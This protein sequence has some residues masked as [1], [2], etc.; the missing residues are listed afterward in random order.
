MNPTSILIGILALAAVVAAHAGLVLAGRR[1]HPLFILGGA[2]LL[3]APLSMADDFQ[4]VG[5]IKFARLY[6]TLLM[7]ALGV[8]AYGL[9]PVGKASAA[10][11]GFAIFYVA[12]S[13][14]S[15]RPTQA[16]LYKG[17]FTMTL[18]AGIFLGHAPRTT[19][20]LLRGLRCLG[21][22]AGIAGVAVFAQFATAPA[23][24]L[25]GGRLA[26]W[27]L[28]AN[29]VAMTAAGL[30]ILCGYL[31]FHE[32]SKRWRA[33][34]LAVLGLLG[35]VIL[36]SGSRGGLLM[37]LV[38]VMVPAVP[39]VKRPGRLAAVLLAAG[40][41]IFAT[42]QLVRVE[43]LDRLADFT[44]GT[45]DSTWEFA[46]KKIHEAP[47]MGHGWIATDR[48]ST[49]NLMSVYLQTLAETGLVGLIV[50]GS[51]LVMIA[52]Q[53]ARM[54]G[55][56]RHAG[57]PLADLSYLALGLVAAVLLHG[58]AES[59]TLLGSTINSFLLGLG[60]GLIDHLPRLAM[61]RKGRPCRKGHRTFTPASKTELASN[62]IHHPAS[63]VSL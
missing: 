59:G 35:I 5:I 15:D 37:A 19:A 16:L 54:H 43:R 2:F 4:S 42:L 57:K 45:R 55:R 51:A 40:V 25:Q 7:L 23:S 12:A 60:V 48:G 39:L 31:A 44:A 8:A 11:L 20:E 29:T 58:F 52:V 46:W 24:S 38:G 17:L 13:Q 63:G 49:A 47:W 33:A 61:R 10:L 27:G 26:V 34:A 18:S 3:L 6:S 21:L 14:W 32:T 50:L 1:V 9:L 36:A 30:A 22:V 28:N 41:M 53:A 56:L 62:L